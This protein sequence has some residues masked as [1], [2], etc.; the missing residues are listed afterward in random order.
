MKVRVEI[1]QASCVLLIPSMA[2]SWQQAVIEQLRRAGVPGPPGNW[3]WTWDMQGQEHICKI[4]S[5]DEEIQEV[6]RRKASHPNFEGGGESANIEEA[7]K[8]CKMV[9]FQGGARGDGQGSKGFKQLRNRQCQTGTAET[10]AMVLTKQATQLR[11]EPRGQV[12][13]PGKGKAKK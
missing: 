9:S 8:R 6:K 1:E 2:S 13:Q 10:I 5:Q 11:M 3:R 12:L 4:E 7:T